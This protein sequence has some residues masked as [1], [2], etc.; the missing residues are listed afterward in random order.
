METGK[1]FWELCLDDKIEVMAESAYYLLTEFGEE[2]LEPS[3][4]EYMERNCLNEICRRLFE[5]KDEVTELSETAK[6]QIFDE[7]IQYGLEHGY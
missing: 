1:S 7:T 4:I 6:E 3:D 2:L 5:D